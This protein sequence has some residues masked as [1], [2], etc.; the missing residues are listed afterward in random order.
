MRIEYSRRSTLA[1]LCLALLLV[2]ACVTGYAEGSDTSGDRL[3]IHFIDVGMADAILL[4]DFQD[5]SVSDMMI[6]TGDRSH[7]VAVTN[8]LIEQGVYELEHLVLTHPHADHIGGA[9]RILNTFE[10]QDALLAPM[11]ADTA[12]YE[13]VMAKLKD[14]GVTLIY[15]QVGDVLTFGNAQLEL[16][17]PAPVL[18]SS[19]NDWS[20]VYMLTY[21]DRRVLFTG[22]AE[23]N[24]EQDM[25]YDPTLDLH[26]DVLKVGHHGSNT[27]TSY[28]FVAA[29]SPTYAVISCD[30]TSKKDYPDV[31]VGMNL[32]DAGCTDILTT[33]VHGTIVLTIT[34]AGDIVFQTDK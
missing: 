8:Y 22:D 18:Y 10:V 28:D 16:Y 5:G 19:E 26:A 20:L 29:V 24:S 6:D 25:L 33:Y 14:K 34:A 2:F 30:V 23:E 3:E 11:E 9:I 13:K 32:M 21:A 27:S 1:A 17:A 4:R 7:T 15:P 12:T 31:E